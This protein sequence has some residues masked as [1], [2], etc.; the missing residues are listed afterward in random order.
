VAAPVEQRRLKVWVLRT[1]VVRMA[2]GEYGS[3]HHPI[4]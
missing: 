4:P 1:E 2:R 3:R